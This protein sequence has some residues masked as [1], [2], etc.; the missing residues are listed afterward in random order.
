MKKILVLAFA[1]AIAGSIFAQE[2]DTRR[3]RRERMDMT[4]VYNRQA[5]RLV[6]DMKLDK[7]K[8]DAFT[9]LYLDYQNARFNVVNPQGG[10]QESKENQVDFKKLT[11]EEAKALVEK[12]FDRQAKQLEVDKQYYAKFC[13]ILTPVQAAQVFI[14]PRGGMMMRGGQ[15]G[16]GGQGGFGGGQRG[17]GFGGGQGG[18]GGFGGPGGGF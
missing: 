13:E 18:G 17:G 15:S 9:A 1:V 6:K 14:S 5:T 8:E 7:E 4:E 10:D 3:E 2:G 16:Q 11:D 12:N